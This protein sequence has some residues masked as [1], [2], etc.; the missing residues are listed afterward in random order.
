MEWDLVDEHGR[1]LRKWQVD[2]GGS[3]FD[4][5]RM[6]PNIPGTPISGM[7]GMPGQFATHMG[8]QMEDQMRGSS[9]GTFQVQLALKWSN[10]GAIC[11]VLDMQNLSTS[12][13]FW[14]V[15]WWVRGTFTTILLTFDSQHRVYIYIYIHIYIYM[16]DVY[17]IRMIYVSKN[18][19]APFYLHSWIKTQGEP[20]AVRWKTGALRTFTSS[21]YSSID[22]F[23]LTTYLVIL[24]VVAQECCMKCFNRSKKRSEWSCTP[25]RNGIVDHGEV[26]KKLCSKVIF[27]MGDV[28]KM[29]LSKFWTIL[30]VSGGFKAFSFSNHDQRSQKKRFKKGAA[31][32][33]SNVRWRAVKKP[34]PSEWISHRLGVPP[35]VLQRNGKKPNNFSWYSVIRVVGYVL[36]F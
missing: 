4:L 14:V 23:I 8:E 30:A 10:F 35:Q 22:E 36:G 5:P 26:C 2:H 32:R 17:S 1:F 16:H 12:I 28:R 21:N 29:R 3:T 34:L 11:Q 19:M 13:E 7:P 25:W 24:D 33:T 31:R 9:E 6:L 18:W 15:S 20:G 27:Q